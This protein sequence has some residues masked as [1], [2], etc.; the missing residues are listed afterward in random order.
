[1]LNSFPNH[2]PPT[3]KG[4]PNTGAQYKMAFSQFMKTDKGSYVCEVNQRVGGVTSKGKVYLSKGN[5]R[6][7][8]ATSAAGQ[9]ITSSMVMK[10][11]YSYTW[12]SMS[13]T[14]GFKV[15]LPTEAEATT[16]ASNQGSASA[17]ASYAWNGD[18]IG[19]YSCEVAVVEDS[20]FALPATIN[21]TEVTR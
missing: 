2:T 18:T 7:D 13:S 16:G 14:M 20:R 12:T 17:Q 6:G 10:D 9:N 19:D 15:K 1:M 8:F 4:L 11:G 3:T 5:I 21:F